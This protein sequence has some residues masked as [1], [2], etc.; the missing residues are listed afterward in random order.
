MACPNV[1]HKL[2]RIMSGKFLMGMGSALLLAG[3]AFLPVMAAAQD[4]PPPM[5]GVRGPGIGPHGHLPVPPG[6][7]LTAEQKVQWRIISEQVKKD[8]AGLRKDGRALHEQIGDAL[9]SEGALDRTK[10]ADLLRQENALHVRE[11]QARL[12]IMEKLHDLLTPAQRKQARET[13]DKMKAL[14]E[15][16]WAL[17][18]KSDTPEPEAP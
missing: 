18:K 5:M 10:L 3:T 13:A 6:V 11:E 4:V 2:E 16:L 8:D 1:L 7:E 12:E 14:H 15:Q 17:M 9:M